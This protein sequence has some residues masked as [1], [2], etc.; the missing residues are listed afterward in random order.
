MG[1]QIVEPECGVAGWLGG[2]CIGIWSAKRYRQ[3]GKD[4]QDVRTVGK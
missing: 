1:S 3:G 4:G 2:R